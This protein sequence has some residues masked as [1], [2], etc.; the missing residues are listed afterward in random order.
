MATM[1]APRPTADRT[2]ERREML[3]QYRARLAAELRE[4]DATIAAMRREQP[5]AASTGKEP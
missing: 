5:P 2:I 4:L 1:E 3:E